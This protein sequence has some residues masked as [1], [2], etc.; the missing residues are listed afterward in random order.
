MTA[1]V[2]ATMT[3]NGDV[4]PFTNFVDGWNAFLERHADAL[5][6]LA[7]VHRPPVPPGV[8]RDTGDDGF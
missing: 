7:G 4:P 6:R 2:E 8:S 3:L 1:R 5:A